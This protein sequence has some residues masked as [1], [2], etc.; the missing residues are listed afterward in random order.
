MAEK[1]AVEAYIGP[2][3]TGRNY[4]SQSCISLRARHCKSRILCYLSSRK[5][6]WNPSCA[7]RR[8]QIGSAGAT[9]FS[10]FDN[11]LRNATSAFTEADE[12]HCAFPQYI[13]CVNDEELIRASYSRAEAMV[14]GLQCRRSRIAIVVF[15]PTLLNDMKH[16]AASVNKPVEVI[17]ERGDVDAV[18][19]AS[20]SGRFLLCAPDYVGG[21][22][23]SGV[24]LV[25]IDGGR[26]PPFEMA[27][28]SGS[29]AFLSYQAHSRL[30][31]AITRARYR[32]EILGSSERGPSGLLGSAFE[33]KAIERISFK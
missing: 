14:A 3:C 33:R 31:V 25:G 10:D 19:R 32:V 12:R 21:L 9:L 15:D 27:T 11:P 13:D 26:V 30:Y 6:L 2:A 5:M 8:L 7:R 22:E 29:A 17:V 23:F 24:V 20:R 1:N 4:G 16:H 28:L 18:R